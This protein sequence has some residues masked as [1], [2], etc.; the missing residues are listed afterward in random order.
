V[1]GS[2]F[3]ESKMENSSYNSTL[4]SAVVPDPPTPLINAYIRQVFR[5]DPT[6]GIRQAHEEVSD[7]YGFHLN[8]FHNV[9]IQ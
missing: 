1:A 9:Y 6:K 7:L 5:K 8:C 3:G 4:R 2:K